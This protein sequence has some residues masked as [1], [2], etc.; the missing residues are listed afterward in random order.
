MKT[1]IFNFN[2]PERLIAQNPVTNRSDSRLL[3]Y[4]RND[5]KIIDSFTKNISDFLSNDNFLVFNN[6]KVIPAR[7]YIKKKE[8]NQEGQILVLKIIDDFSLEI[9]T[10]RSKKYKQGTQIILPDQNISFISENV[11]EFVKILRSDKPIFSIDYLEKYGN[12]PLPPYIK[13]GKADET[14]SQ[15]YQTIYKK[16]Y[17]SAAAPTAGLHFDDIIFNNL[18]KKK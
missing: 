17:G 11:D 9:I 8:N 18:S 15:R 14:D 12:I 7:L 2:I 10:D 4:Y 16:Y 1:D 5:N 3:V 13:K 6:S